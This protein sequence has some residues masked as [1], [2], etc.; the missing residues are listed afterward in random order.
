MDDDHSIDLNKKYYK[1]KKSAVPEVARGLVTEMTCDEETK[2]FLRDC[3]SVG[4]TDTFRN[5][6]CTLLRNFMSLTDANGYL[7]RGQ[8]FVYSSDHFHRLVSSFIPIPAP[9]PLDQ[10]EPSTTGISSLSLLDV[11][12]G[13]GHVTDRMRPYFGRVVTTEASY[14]MCARLRARGY[15]C[16]EATDLTPQSLGDH[17]IGFDV[18][19]CLNV[20]DRC[21]TP[22][23]LLKEMKALL[24]PGGIIVLAVVVPW[25]P[26]VENGT[27]Q[28][29]PSERLPIPPGCPCK[30]NVTAMPFETSVGHF[31]A[32]VLNPI[33]LNVVRVSRVPYLCRGDDVKP[34]YMLDDALFVCKPQD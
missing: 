16:V 15:P 26:F 8:M 28:Q 27:V 30:G 32:D 1:I 2:L 4:W 3:Y 5:M 24:K 6:A 31:V 13:D 20:L 14:R 33:G 18:I 11:G 23:V 19:T 10:P 9:T 29:P 17:M 7:G 12:A 34:Y 22:I 21:D 25:C